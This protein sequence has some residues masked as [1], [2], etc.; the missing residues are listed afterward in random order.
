MQALCTGLH[1]LDSDRAF[2][3]A[4]VFASVCLRQNNRRV[5]IFSVWSYFCYCLLSPTGAASA[6]LC[7]YGCLPFCYCGT[8]GFIFHIQ[9]AYK[10]RASLCSSSFFFWDNNI[11]SDNTDLLS[12]PFSAVLWLPAGTLRQNPAL[13]AV[14][15]IYKNVIS[16]QHIFRVRKR[17]FL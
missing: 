5:C 3:S 15:R 1:R 13:W 2:I 4:P 10:S 14:Y 8:D 17:Y 12:S 16:F 11:A 6:D 9:Q 7:C